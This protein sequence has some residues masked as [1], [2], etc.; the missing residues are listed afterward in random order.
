MSLPS[1]RIQFLRRHQINAAEWDACVLASGAPLVYAQ[2]WYLDC[3]APNWCALT[4]A[5]PA[6]KYLAVWPLPVKWRFGAGFVYQPHFSQQLGL[7]ARPEVEI[8]VAEMLREMPLSIRFA[9]VN[10]HAGQQHLGE[11]PEGFQASERITHELGLS[12][13]FDELRRGYKGNLRRSVQKPAEA[14]FQIREVQLVEKT[15][16]LFRQ[17]RG[18]QVTE[19]K[20]R[21]Y[22]RL[23]NLVRELQKRGAA[24]LLEAQLN[25]ETLSGAVLVKFGEKL[26]YLFAG[27]SEK[28]RQTQANARLLDFVIQQHAGQNLVLDFEGGNL[29]GIG[30]FFR[31]FGAVPVP[32]VSLKLN[33][34]PWPLSKVIK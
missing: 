12:K 9:Q 22:E 7:L 31:S 2:S 3:V 32:F 29:P 11:L 27:N 5:N 8:T 24:L 1:S 25:N 16:Q 23:R 34:L 14:D 21:D 33:R 20:N 6:K 13:P 26:I 18:S 15:I 17:S 30:H 10:L 19:L 4:L 28:A